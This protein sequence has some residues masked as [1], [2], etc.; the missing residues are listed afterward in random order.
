MNLL[1]KL[2]FCVQLYEYFF[3]GRNGVALWL[4]KTMKCGWP[5]YLSNLFIYFVWDHS[6]FFCLEPK[7][8]TLRDF[9]KV[10]EVHAFKLRFGAK[11]RQIKTMEIQVAFFGWTGCS[12]HSF[13]HR[14]FDIMQYS[15]H[16]FDCRIEC[17]ESLCGFMPVWYFMQYSV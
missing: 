3:E 13:I 8:P 1:Y 4:M 2:Q 16:D 5:F 17:C 6:V 10:G 12:Y 15:S 7:L 9:P 11:L 14:W